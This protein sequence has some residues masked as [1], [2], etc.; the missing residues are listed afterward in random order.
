MEIALFFALLGLAMG[1]HTIETSPEI[2]AGNCISYKCSDSEHSIKYPKCAFMVDNTYYSH[3]TCPSDEVCVEKTAGYI[4]ESSSPQNLTIYPGEECRSETDV[5]TGVNNCS[6]DLEICNGLVEGENC[7]EKWDCNPG[8][9]CHEYSENNKTCATLVP[10]GQSCTADVTCQLDSGC[11]KRLDKDSKYLCTR[12]L[13]LPVGTL[14]ENEGDSK[15]CE[16]QYAFKAKGAGNYNCTDSLKSK[17]DLPTPCSDSCSSTIDIATN[18]SATSSCTCSFSVVPKKYCGLFYGDQ[19]GKDYM[20]SYRKYLDKGIHKCNTHKPESAR[21]MEYNWNKDDYFDLMY[22]QMTFHHYAV[23]QDV[24]S[25][26]KEVF[27]PVYEMYKDEHDF[28]EWLA[29]PFLAL[30]AF[31]A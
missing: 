1:I 10:E 26:T 11:V 12:K 20:E 16:N 6:K 24:E 31:L 18:Q 29:V 19:I 21:C 27:L 23:I 8:L 17:S 7:T 14:V 5:C 3:N 22:Y 13:S 30:L 28:G 25:C 4:C 2:L 9:Y 15:Y